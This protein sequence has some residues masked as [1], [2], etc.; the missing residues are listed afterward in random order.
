M[1][2]PRLSSKKK[3]GRS[4]SRA[5]SQSQS[6]SQKLTIN[7]GRNTTQR[8]TRS[9]GSSMTPAPYSQNLVPFHIQTAPAQQP[10]VDY[11]RIAR[12]TGSLQEQNVP[13]RSIPLQE[14]VPVSVPVSNVEPRRDGPTSAGFELTP[15]EARVKQ[16]PVVVPKP[17]KKFRLEP[18]PEETGV[19]IQPIPKKPIVE[20][21][22]KSRGVEPSK[23]K[24]SLK[25][26][27]ERKLMTGQ[28]F[29]A[30][31]VAVSKPVHVAPPVKVLP[32]TQGLLEAKEAIS[33]IKKAFSPPSVTTSLGATSGE[34]SFGAE[35]DPEQ[36]L[37]GFLSPFGTVKPQPK[38]KKAPGRPKGA[39]NK[40]KPIKT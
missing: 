25:E 34:T 8:K 15:S 12:M 23:P 3:R 24:G 30:P 1:D 2:K 14:H 6:Q 10:L 28:D 5:K 31:E 33:M 7:I 21:L 16:E 11:D 13:N 20:A 18:K 29:P 19:I 22:G 35:A 32:P 39:K 4:K 36:D 27:M 38:E 26:K 17:I 9:S 40:P 37:G